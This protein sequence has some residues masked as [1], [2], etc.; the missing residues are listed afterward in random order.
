M[1]ARIFA[2]LLFI[3]TASAALAGVGPIIRHTDHVTNEYIVALTDRNPRA[4]PGIANSIAASYDGTI[5]R[6]FD[7]VLG[8]FS[9]LLS[10]EA[11]DA[12]NADPRVEYVE[13]NGIFDL[14]TPELSARRSTTYNAKSLWYLDR[15]DDQYP[16]QMDNTYDYCATGNNVY[17]YVLDNG[18]WANH[19]ELT[20][21]VVTSL[22]FANPADPTPSDPCSTSPSGWHGTAIGT[23][24]AG[25]N[26]GVASN[27]K[28]IS[29]AI[30]NCSGSITIAAYTAALNWILHRDCAP[31]DPNCPAGRQQL[32]TFVNFPPNT[33]VTIDENGNVI[34]S[35]PGVINFSGYRNP[36]DRY[37]GAPASPS[38]EKATADVVAKTN[39][40]FVTAANNFSVDTANYSPSNLGITEAAR[41]A[42]P[43]AAQQ[44]ASYQACSPSAAQCSA[45]AL[46]IDGRSTTAQHRTS[47]A[48]AAPIQDPRSASGHRPRT[49]TPDGIAPT[50]THSG[51][52]CNKYDTASGTSFA[53]PIVAAMAARYINR[54]ALDL[55][56]RPTATEVYSF[57]M[58]NATKNI[59]SGTATTAHYLWRNKVNA[60]DIIGTL[61][62]T[63][64]L[65]VNG[66]CA[67]TALYDYPSRQLYPSVT[68]TAAGMAYWMENVDPTTGSC[69]LRPLG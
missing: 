68:N 16:Y 28:I 17:V 67:Y 57:L 6:I 20:G 41:P 30:A 62:S 60:D 66:T 52:P 49:S 64:P 22:N 32:S 36:K 10:P 38:V 46:T 8:G 12:L 43:K 24:I 2:T 35:D 14:N 55:Q 3:V 48:T 50:R 9:V 26:I 40:P 51:S 61:T 45:M 15:I 21:K 37:I 56:P 5:T 53:S 4:I 47:T 58:T 34:A 23:L 13:E 39:F 42:S 54:R 19:P 18:V 31:T 11:A 65:I 59:V 29:L 7:E 27:A 25:T 63:C 44:L 69:R 1:K 33:H